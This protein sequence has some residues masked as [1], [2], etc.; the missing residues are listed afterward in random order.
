M[1]RSD[2]AGSNMNEPHSKEA[3]GDEGSGTHFESVRL[4]TEQSVC[5]GE[6]RKLV[7]RG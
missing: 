7:D 5:S 4:K 1:S 3:C 2:K 6:G